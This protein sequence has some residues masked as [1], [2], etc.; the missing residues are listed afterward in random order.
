MN[1]GPVNKSWAVSLIS[2]DL[3]LHEKRSAV[4]D[5]LRDLSF[6]PVAFEKKDFPVQSKLHSHD[7]CLK[8]IETMD[9]VLLLVDWR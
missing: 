1:N 2:T 6:R 3:D 8:A 4:F 5:R 7:V 9:I